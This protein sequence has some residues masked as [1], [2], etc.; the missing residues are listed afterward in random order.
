MLAATVWVESNFNP[1]LVSS[2]GAIGL[3]QLMPGT[4][5]WLG[6]DPWDPAQNLDGGANYLRMM[7][8]RYGRWDLAHAAYNAGPIRVDAA[9]PGMPDLVETQLHVA[10]VLERYAQLVG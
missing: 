2:A 5:A 7:Y 9:G 4:A 1:T 3:A 10:R 6:V 8:Q